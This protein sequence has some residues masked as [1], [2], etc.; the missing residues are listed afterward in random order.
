MKQL[1]TKR[2]IVCFTFY[3]SLS[4]QR[5]LQRNKFMILDGFWQ[6]IQLNICLHDQRTDLIKITI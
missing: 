6:Q 3:N 5:T 4:G 1:I 2:T